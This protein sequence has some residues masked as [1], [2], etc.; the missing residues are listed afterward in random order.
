MAAGASEPAPALAKRPSY[1]LAD[2][3]APIAAI[4]C[5][6]LSLSMSMPL[7]GLL[8]ERAG[9]SG[10]VIGLSS[11]AAPFAMVLLA[12]V[13][14]LAIRLLGLVRFFLAATMVG[15]LSL[16]AVPLVD[17]LVAWSALRGT[18]GAATVALFVAAEFW[19]VACAPAAL[20][21]RIIALYG[22]VVTAAFSAGPMVIL[23]TGETGV[24]P[25]ATAAMLALL[26]LIP[27]AAGARRAPD[28]EDDGVAP[29][30]TAA[31]RYLRSDPTLLLAVF[32]FGVIEYGALSLH[33]AWALRAGFSVEAG[34]TLLSLFSL[35][36]ML[37][38][39]PLG[40]A[41]DRFETRRLLALTAAAC[42]VAPLG[43]AAAAPAF[44]PTG[45]AMLVWGGF[46]AALYSLAL[47][48]LGARYQGRALVEA[49]AAIALAYG[50]GAL[51][52]PALMGLA[53]DLV[54]PPHGLMLSAAV[55]AAL[56]L[57]LV[58]ARIIL[59]PR[60]RPAE[61]AETGGV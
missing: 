40:W 16:V 2:Q 13:M 45:G 50:A 15:A 9:Y 31:L 41:A 18:W 38:S 6:A 36:A 28:P 53:M 35:G 19:I 30:P 60:D 55:I 48:G 57:G 12:P 17:G 44:L 25:F 1:G 46:G 3:I 29:S 4:S 7:F 52:A 61:T 21:G 24:L 34:V 27:L 33:P 20:R 59:R 32:L 39:L 43:L 22:I 37:L 51:A 14:P 42:A 56:Y 49:S 47:Y 58:V 54:V 8:L 11:M 26:G 5:F 10:T 23:L